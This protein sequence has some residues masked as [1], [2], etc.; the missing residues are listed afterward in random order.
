[1]NEESLKQLIAQGLGALQAGAKVGAKAA[2]DVE[3]DA[4]NAELKEHLK[5]GSETAKMWATRIDTALEEAGGSDTSDNPIIEAHYEV[6]NRI[7]SEA[8]DD[9]ARDLG[10]IAASQLALHYWIAS[11]GT[12]R[13]YAKRADLS[14]TQES[15]NKCLEEA[16]QA[17][18]AFTDVAIKMMEA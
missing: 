5:K 8:A 2:D 13:A 17:D 16:E 9:F 1:M 10:I 6:A 12:M 15:M 4:S 11:F 18:E 14:Q 3:N 7:R